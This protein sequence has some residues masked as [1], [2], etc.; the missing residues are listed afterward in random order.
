VHVQLRFKYRLA[1]VGLCHTLV[2]AAIRTISLRSLPSC[3][4]LRS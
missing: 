4:I 3:A 2:S 1:Q